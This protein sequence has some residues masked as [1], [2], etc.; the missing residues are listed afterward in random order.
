MDFIKVE[1]TQELETALVLSLNVALAKKETVLWLV[2]GGSNI[3][4]ASAIMSGLRK[5][6]LKQL[7]IALTDER[8]GL[9]GHKDSN[10]FQLHEAGFDTHGATFHDLLQGASFADTI[11]EGAKAME[12]VFSQTKTIIGFFGMGPDG[13]IAGILPGSPAAVNEKVWM[14]GY[15]GGQF[16]RFTLTPFALSHV[17]QAFVG[18]FGAEKRVALTTLHDKIV[19]IAEQPAQI[20][21]HIPEVFIYNNQIGDK[22]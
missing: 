15:D 19:P 6:N 7:T 14:T 18:T 2:P 22:I 17:Q 21:R 20:L 10:Y 9:S 4:V 3:T 13:H 5:E 12:T 8:Y 1:S 16:Q 11:S